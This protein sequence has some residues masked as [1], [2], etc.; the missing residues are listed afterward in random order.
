MNTTHPNLT[1]TTMDKRLQLIQRLYGETDPAEPLTEDPALRPE[2][3]T[4]LM[5][6]SVLDRLPP[7]S[8]P[9]PTVLVNLMTHAK[10]A[11][12]N[13]SGLSEESALPVIAL[14]YNQS[15]RP[16]D[17]ILKDEAH[18]KEYDM[19]LTA[20]A[21][22]EQ[23]RTRPQPNPEVIQAILKAANASQPRPRLLYIGRHLL[24]KPV[25][26]WVV[27]ASVVLVAIGGFFSLRTFWSSENTMAGLDGQQLEIYEPPASERVFSWDERPV[28]STIS[29]RVEH[30]EARVEDEWGNSPVPIEL[31]RNNATQNRNINPR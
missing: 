24:Q 1:T 7:Q 8:G 14:L 25:A 20:K 11:T 21:F 15:H 6:K 5:V 26:R 17:E 30:L 2:L 31:T 23:P 29:Q 19:L 13:T 9:D 18:R 27:A 28:F 10:T 12:Q 22:L 4:L 3:D 16:A